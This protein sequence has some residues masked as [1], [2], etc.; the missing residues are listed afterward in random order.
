MSVPGGLNVIL[1]QI[2][3]RELI[4]L[5]IIIMRP[6]YWNKSN[7][8]IGKQAFQVRAVDLFNMMVRSAGRK[9]YLKMCIE[10]T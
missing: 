7:Y 10:Q 2:N 3:I 9:E 4:M 6:K 1:E 5:R 8:R